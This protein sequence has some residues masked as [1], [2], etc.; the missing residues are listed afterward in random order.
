MENRFEP[1][2]LPSWQAGEEFDSL[3][4]SYATLL[5]LGKPSNLNA[6]VISE[7]ILAR[8]EGIFGEIS[9][10]LIRAAVLAITSG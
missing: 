1:L 6:P 2:L 3:L 5:P 9:T 10:I 7:K 4:A 8:S